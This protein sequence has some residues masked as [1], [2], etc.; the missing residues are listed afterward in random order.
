[1]TYAEQTTHRCRAACP[2]KHA[3]IIDW[4]NGKR[5]TVDLSAFLDQFLRLHP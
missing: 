5:H 1:M 2:G 3:L 4:N